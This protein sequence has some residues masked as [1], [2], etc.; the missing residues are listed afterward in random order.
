MNYNTLLQILQKSSSSVVGPVLCDFLNKSCPLPIRFS[1]KIISKYGMDRDKASTETQKD[2]TITRFVWDSAKQKSTGNFTFYLRAEQDLSKK[3]QKGHEDIMPKFLKKWRAFLAEKDF[4][5]AGNKSTWK[6]TEIL[7]TPPHAASATLVAAGQKWVCLESI[8]PIEVRRLLSEHVAKWI[9]ARYAD[10]PLPSRVKRNSSSTT[11]L[12]NND[13]HKNEEDEDE[14]S[15][16]ESEDEK[17]T[18]SNTN[19]N[20]N[21]SDDESDEEVSTPKKP[22]QPEKIKPSS[23]HVLLPSPQPVVPETKIQLVS[24]DIYS[25]PLDTIRNDFEFIDDPLLTNSDGGN[26]ALIRMLERAQQ[27]HP[28]QYIPLQE[29]QVNS[30]YYDTYSNLF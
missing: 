24:H 21:S 22:I 11:P 12:K 26:E 25:Q 7:C 13:H 9:F 16:S 27:Q 15:N 30:V 18:H 8:F 4:G 28:D 14:D 3:F 2:A 1:G 10:H 29:V 19:K 17:H 23:T 6:D 20:K 5:F